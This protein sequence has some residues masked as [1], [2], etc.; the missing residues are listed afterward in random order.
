MNWV[1]L[2]LAGLAAVPAQPKTSAL[3]PAHRLWRTGRYDEAITAA[4]AS[5]GAAGTTLA[6]SYERQ[7]GRYD[8]ARRTLEPVTHK[9]AGAQSLRARLELGR[10]A[11]ATG[12]K[13]EGEALL[14]GFY[15]DWNAGRVDQTRVEP[16]VC[17]AI[18]AREL[19]SY[20][21]ANRTFQKAFAIDGRNRELLLEWARTFLDRYA[22]GEAE[23]TLH[24]ALAADADDPDV[25]ALLARVRMDQS[26]FAAAQV[27]AARALL[28]NP[29]HLEAL[30]VRAEL[31]L[32]DGL[33]AEAARD[34]DRA[35]SIAPGVARLHALKAAA[36]HQAD[37]RT[38]Y[39]AARTR[40]L[41]INPG[42]AEF[43]HVVAELLV[44]HHRYTDAIALEEQALALD[45]DHAGARAALGTN[46]LRQGD[47]E[48]G[49]RELKRAWE[50]DPF[51]VRTFNI[52]NLFEDVLA[53]HFIFVNA[54]PF[55][56]RVLREHAPLLEHVMP[57]VLRVAYDDFVKR[58]QYTP[59]AGVT[60]E[61]YGNA[62]QYAVRTVGLPQLGA[63]G[64]CFGRVITAL[65]PGTPFARFSWA[66]VLSH[67]LAHVFAIGLS[68]SRVPRWFTEGLSEWETARMRPEW[69]R[70]GD[71]DL[72]AAIAAHKLTPLAELSLGF[73]HARTMSEMTTAYYH[74]Y[75]AV[76]FLIRRFGWNAIVAMLRGFGEGR[77]A[78]EVIAR[79]SGQPIAALDAELAREIERRTK[80]YLDQLR[81]PESVA[82]TLAQ[83]AVRAR[84]GD[85]AAQARLG[86]ARLSARDLAGAAAAAQTA[87]SRNPTE[88]L[89]WLLRGEVA[90]AGKHA[91]EALTAYQKVIDLGKD[92]F[93]V[94]MRLG[95]A[96][97]HTG[98]R[99]R[100]L[101]EFGR[102][103]ALDPQRDEPAAERA[104]MYEQMN[105]RDAALAELEK[106]VAIDP[107]AGPAA[108]KLALAYAERGLTDKTARY[109]RR[110]LEVN[111]FDAEVARALEKAERALGHTQAAAA[112]HKTAELAAAAAAS[113]EPAA[114]A[115]G[116]GLPDAP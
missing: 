78:T 103:Q 109:A 90:M 16:L 39:D 104:T 11:L 38:G 111:P 20:Q 79:V 66:M 82:L 55:R 101:A 50:V 37:D 13:A 98:D 95:A 88:P 110:A 61:L 26:D 17:V 99:E 21:D 105:Q 12:H 54:L 7:L 85:A 76:D 45:P 22:D 68:R 62:S 96:A 86:F 4:R 89:G 15:Q 6:G 44:H 84:P 75:V 69:R 14:D 19:G 32:E 59:P 5:G 63:L 3:A 18:A 115:S 2:T 29:R 81:A 53:K 25:H 35:I 97:E 112:A 113:A 28:I 36:P 60:F 23:S 107:N 8:D 51:N 27:E 64:V 83:E 108:R 58:Y 87:L 49:L 73:T 65:E 34:L 56:L 72:A 42:Y 1:A 116:P 33:P 48:H 10:V 67:E 43:Y 92:G 80:S 31:L 74:S 71:A 102:A 114:S 52:L 94:R 77:P 57:P 24:D 100:A 30:A 47:D 106:Q 91:A 9:F 41:A 70:P 40:A 93:D 46:Y